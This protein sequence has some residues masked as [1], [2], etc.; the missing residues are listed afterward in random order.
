[1]LLLKGK[2]HTI[3]CSSMLSPK[4]TEDVQTKS[5]SPIPGPDPR[6]YTVLHLRS[7]SK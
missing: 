1:M 6:L 2:I 3:R 4:D 7:P 5:P